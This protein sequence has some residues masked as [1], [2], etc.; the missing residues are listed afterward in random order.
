MS[1]PPTSQRTLLTASIALGTIW[2]YQG[3]VP[4]ILFPDTGELEMF[5]TFDLF[6]GYETTVLV[7]I[8]LVEV[9][10]GLVILFIRRKFI[11][12]I[13]MVVLLFLA[14]GAMVSK[15]IVYVFPFNPLTLTIAMMALSL[16]SIFRLE[17]MGPGR[18]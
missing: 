12:I 9:V 3:I 15:P 14:S 1:R 2:I 6:Q 17:G 18:R 13:N 16:I 4:K 5:K 7:L 8:G 10:F 11:H